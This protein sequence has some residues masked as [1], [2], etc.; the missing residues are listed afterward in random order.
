MMRAAAALGHEYHILPLDIIDP[1]ERRWWGP[2]RLMANMDLT[3]WA[4]EEARLAK[5]DTSGIS[6][7][8][9]I[10]KTRKSLDLSQELEMD[11]LRKELRRSG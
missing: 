5:G 7:G 11:K 1:H 8:R 10:E 2:E 3:T 6:V 4:L 9:Q